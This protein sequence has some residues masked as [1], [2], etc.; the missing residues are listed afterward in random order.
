MRV[1]CGIYC[2]RFYYFGSLAV[3]V[4]LLWAK[5]KGSFSILFGGLC[6]CCLG[7]QSLLQA[8]IGLVIGSTVFTWSGMSTNRTALSR[9][10]MQNPSNY[11]HFI[12]ETMGFTQVHTYQSRPLAKGTD[13]NITPPAPWIQILLKRQQYNV[14]SV[15]EV[16]PAKAKWI[17]N[18]GTCKLSR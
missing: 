16:Y 17:W 4:S 7:I 13:K 3:L 11:H 2:N 6:Y 18:A 15:Y 14:Y 1:A 9:P 5:R 12:W 8:V 10:A